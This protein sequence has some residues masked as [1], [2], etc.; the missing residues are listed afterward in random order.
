MQG[1]EKGATSTM[2]LEKKENFGIKCFRFCL[3]DIGDFIFDKIR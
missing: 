1:M 3:F 2:W